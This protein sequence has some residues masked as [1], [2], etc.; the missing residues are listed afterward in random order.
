MTNQT[1]WIT[2]VK[3]FQVRVGGFTTDHRVPPFVLAAFGC[4]ADHDSLTLYDGSRWDR[5]WGRDSTSEH[6]TFH[7]VTPSHHRPLCPARVRDR[8]WPTRARYEGKLVVVTERRTVAGGV[9]CR[10][11]RDNTTTNWPWTVDAFTTAEDS[12]TYL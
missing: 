1:R 11:A 10:V 7:C 2:D 3:T 9:A 5:V 4:D 6:A 8:W 12:L